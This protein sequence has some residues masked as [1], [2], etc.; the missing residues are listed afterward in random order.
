MHDAS[1]PQDPRKVQGQEAE[2]RA[3]AHLKTQGFEVLARNARYKVG[4]IDIVAREGE[5]LCFVEV[6]SRSHP[7]Q[8]HPAATVDRRKQRQIIKAAMA[9]CQH[10]RIKDT[11]LRFDVVAVTGQEIEL[12]RNAFE[13]WR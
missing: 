6:R 12:I 8:V 1:D 4:E 7:G 10:H 3:A 11:M 5:T 9:Y 13:A 2:D